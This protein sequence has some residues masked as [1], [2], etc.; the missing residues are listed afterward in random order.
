M[1]RKSSPAQQWKKE[2]RTKVF[3]LHDAGT[4]AVAVGENARFRMK[5][6]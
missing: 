5:R 2:W 3:K 1:Y 6:C 4:G